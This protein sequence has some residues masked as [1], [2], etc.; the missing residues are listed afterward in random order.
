MFWVRLD[1]S[2]DNNVISVDE[3]SSTWDFMTEFVCYY[4]CFVSFFFFILLN[5]NKEHYLFHHCAS[6]FHFFSSMNCSHLLQVCLSLFA[7][8]CICAYTYWY[9]SLKIIIVYEN[10]NKTFIC[11]LPNIPRNAKQSLSISIH[12]YITNTIMK[13]CLSKFIY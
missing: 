12:F 2:S 10:S 11:L 8:E 13:T 6:F 1:T 7:C 9:M 4:N 5:K 3:S